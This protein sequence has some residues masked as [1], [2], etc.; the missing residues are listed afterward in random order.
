MKVGEQCSCLGTWQYMWLPY[1]IRLVEL[2]MYE[3]RQLPTFW[4]L[5]LQLNKPLSFKVRFHQCLQGRGKYF[6]VISTSYL[7]V[8]SLVWGLCRGLFKRKT[9]Y[10]AVGKW[11]GSF[12]TTGH[13]TTLETAEVDSCDWRT[14]PT[15]IAWSTER[16]EGQGEQREANDLT[17]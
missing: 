12:P 3:Q 2:A 11:W 1:G 6:T 10:K 14:R 7:M 16:R 9:I 4:S 17:Y 13:Q 15:L 5:F 8:W